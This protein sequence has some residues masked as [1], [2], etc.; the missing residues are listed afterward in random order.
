MTEQEQEDMIEFLR[1]LDFAKNENGVIRIVENWF[2]WEELP[3]TIQN[4]LTD[5]FRHLESID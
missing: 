4:Y 3:A 1:M 5:Y 2:T